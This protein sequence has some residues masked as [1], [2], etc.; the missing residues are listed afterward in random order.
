VTEPKQLD[1]VINDTLLLAQN[2]LEKLFHKL[3]KKQIRPRVAKRVGLESVAEAHS[4]LEMDKARGPVVC[5]PWKRGTR[6]RHE[7]DNNEARQVEEKPKTH[8][9]LLF[10]GR[11]KAEKDHGKEDAQSKKTKGPEKERKETKG[12]EKERKETKG[13]EKER[14]ETKGSEKERDKKSKSK[15]SADV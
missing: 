12:S 10:G 13:S 5:I 8:R 3:K 6:S 14:K 11:D 15:K 4:F 7:D 9:N 2:D 1:Y